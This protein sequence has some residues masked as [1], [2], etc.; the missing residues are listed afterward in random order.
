M[1]VPILKG[2]N[3][4]KIKDVLEE[5]PKDEPSKQ[6]Y[7]EISSE[8]GKRLLESLEQD[9]YPPDLFNEIKERNL[10]ITVEE[11]ENLLEIWKRQGMIKGNRFNGYHKK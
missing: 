6:T 4:K 3:T 10:D 7:L 9:F 2:D 11:I 5:V 8:I 1:L